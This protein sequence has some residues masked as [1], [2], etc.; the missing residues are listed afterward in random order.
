MKK[1]LTKSKLATLSGVAVAVILALSTQ[2]KFA[3]FDK[4]SLDE[5]LQLLGIIGV[6][7]LGYFSTFKDRKKPEN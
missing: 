2:F 4:K 3:N 7:T 1:Y 6:A 5:W